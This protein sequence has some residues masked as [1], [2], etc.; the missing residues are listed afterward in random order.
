M[1]TLFSS[2]KYQPPDEIGGDCVGQRAVAKRATHNV[3][4]IAVTRFS[5]IP[6]TTLSVG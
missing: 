3:L 2:R 4:R 5:E 6:A 1:I